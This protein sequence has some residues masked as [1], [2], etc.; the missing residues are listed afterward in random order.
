AA[1]P[2]PKRRRRDLGAFL[3]P[4]RDR[5]FTLAWSGRFFIITGY[6]VVGVYLLYYLA[7]VV[8][9][10]DRVAGGM[11]PEAGHSVVTAISLCGVVLVTLAAAATAWRFKRR[12]PYAA[13]AGGLL[14]L[15]AF[16][17]AL[18]SS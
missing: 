12:K 14:A 6:A 13:L 7:D 15:G 3:R 18:T 16:M 4:F 1:V 5:D 2:A 11:S 9:V 17:L 8:R 10:S